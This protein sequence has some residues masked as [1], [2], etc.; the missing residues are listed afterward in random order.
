MKEKY[1]YFNYDPRFRLPLY[2]TVFHDSVVATHHWNN[3]SLKFVN[4]ADIVA[5][6]EARFTWFRPCTI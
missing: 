2:E 1:E 3:A 4:V 6:T 5:L